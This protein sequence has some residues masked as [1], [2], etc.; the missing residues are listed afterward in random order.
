[1][2]AV[3]LSLISL[4]I[5]ALCVSDTLTQSL[6]EKRAIYAG[7]SSC[8]SQCHDKQVNSF[9]NNKH[10]KAYDIIKDTARYKA[11]KE[12]GEEKSCLPCHT[13]GY[14]Q[15]GGFKGEETTPD[16]AKVGCESCHGP[17]SA[18]I[19]V[20]ADDKAGKKASIRRKPDCGICH[21]IHT[22]S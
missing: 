20:K 1:M 3:L 11:L 4:I 7:N 13:T 9:K 5:M 22:H 21:L 10:N 12:K 15:P 8:L 2:K 18:H 14:G 17:G 19:A 16:Q 6:A